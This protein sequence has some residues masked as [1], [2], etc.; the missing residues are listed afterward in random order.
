MRTQ[1]CGPAQFQKRLG[2]A[3]CVLG[4]RAAFVVAAELNSLSQGQF[5]GEVDRVRLAPHVTLPAIA[6]ALA[7]TAGIFFAAERA[8]DFRAAGSGIYVSNAAIASDGTHESLCF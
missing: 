2:M 5:T 1:G 3:K 8:A 6:S 7:S 4:R